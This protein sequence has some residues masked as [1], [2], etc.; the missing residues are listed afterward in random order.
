MYAFTTPY[1]GPM[2]LGGIPSPV[3]TPPAEQLDDVTKGYVPAGKGDFLFLFL[4]IS[5]TQGVEGKF[6]VVP[7]S[8]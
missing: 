6:K 2:V 8:F 7:Y 1:T 3:D 4:Y 5:T